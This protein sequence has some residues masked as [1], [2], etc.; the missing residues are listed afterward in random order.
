[1]ATNVQR[2]FPTLNLAP[3]LL[4]DVEDLATQARASKGKNAEGVFARATVIIAVIALEHFID[5]YLDRIKPETE[6]R[7]IEREIKRWVRDP[8]VAHTVAAKWYVVSDFY[9]PNRF[10]TTVAPFT[11]LRKLVRLRNDVVH[12]SQ[13]HVKSRDREGVPNLLRQV[14]WTR[15]E[16]A[17]DTTKAI[18]AAFY[19]MAYKAPPD[20]LNP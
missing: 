12:L 14:N 18:I 5:L 2:R 9:T 20:W 15:A 7:K 8:K 16:W 3:L 19:Q 1:M 10:L 6:K 11:E 17:R 13:K 4:R